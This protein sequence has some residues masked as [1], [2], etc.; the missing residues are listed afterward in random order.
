MSNHYTTTEDNFH[1][2][3]IT[4]LFLDISKQGSNDQ[5]FFPSAKVKM[6][7]LFTEPGYAMLG[8]DILEHRC[9]DSSLIF[10]GCNNINL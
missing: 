10:S 9:V 6:Q 4:I 7:N 1:L 8:E 5:P 3:I 2:M